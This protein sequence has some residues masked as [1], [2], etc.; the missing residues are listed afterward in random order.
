MSFTI[1][2][3]HRQRSHSQV[4]VPRDSW[5]HV[6]VSDSRILQAGGPGPCIYIPEEQGGPVVPPGT[7][8]ELFRVSRSYFILVSLDP[9]FSDTVTE[10][11]IA[12]QR[13]VNTA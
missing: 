9:G 2:A 12:R 4:R 13:A 3:G 7:G 8:L 1:A 5:P 11:C 6:T 10:V